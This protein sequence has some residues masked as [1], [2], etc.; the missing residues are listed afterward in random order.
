MAT[1]R[2]WLTHEGFDWDN[3]TVVY[4]P[5]SK[6][7]YSPG[8][9]ERGGNP[10]RIDDG[11]HPILD[12][13]FNKGYGAPQCPRFF[14]KDNRAVYFPGQYDGATWCETVVHNIDAYLGDDALPTP[15]PG[16]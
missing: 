15:Y 14:A 13:E 3:G 11:N 10:V 8:W 6:E 5:V 1:I 16:G 2:Q 7:S 12:H 9:G 4:H